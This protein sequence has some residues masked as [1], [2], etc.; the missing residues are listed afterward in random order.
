ML[1]YLVHGFVVPA[2]LVMVL[3]GAAFADERTAEQTIQEE[4]WAIPVILPT[5]AYVV[6]P[7]GK[8]P[9]AQPERTRLLSTGGVQGRRDVVRE[10][11]L[12]GRCAY[13]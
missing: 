1:G 2:T 11:G 9:F 5:I 3:A 7:V 13:R 10:E 12:H 6:R 4:V 8:G